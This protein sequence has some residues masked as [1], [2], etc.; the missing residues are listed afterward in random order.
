MIQLNPN[1]KILLV[2][3]KHWVVVLGKALVFLL[4]V[5]APLVGITLL[6]SSSFQI[7][8]PVSVVVFSFCVY[9]MVLVLLMFLFWLDYYF[10]VWIITTERIIDIEQYGLFHREVSEFMLIHVEDVSIEIPGILA[11]FM[12]FGTITIQTAGEESFKITQVPRIYEAKNLILQ[13][14]MVHN[15]HTP[16]GEIPHAEDKQNPSQSNQKAVH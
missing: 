2:L 4:L 16:V 5:I 6:S 1:E 9:L 3:H 12:K 7:T 8:I 11:T 13:Y 15:N 14:S 10:D